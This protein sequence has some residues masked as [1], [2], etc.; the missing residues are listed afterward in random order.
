MLQ[1]AHST[2]RY[3][4]VR[5]LPDSFDERAVRSQRIARRCVRSICQTFVLLLLLALFCLRLPQVEGRSMFPGIQPEDRVLINTTA[6]R[7]RLGSAVIPSGALRRGDVVAFYRDD[8]EQTRIFLKRVA[9]LPGDRVSMSNGSLV[10]NGSTMIPQTFEAGA[11]QTSMPL[12]TI[13]A[14]SV[15]VL[16]DNRG[17][18]EDS[19]SFG[20]VALEALIG[21]AVVVIWPPSHV[22]RVR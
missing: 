13:P 4:R 16:G 5:A 20:P 18:S 14:G 21:K 15:F 3:S 19:R 10:V 7:V 12:Q 22:R 1:P 8:G 9:A 17:Q 2:R 6:Y 11:D